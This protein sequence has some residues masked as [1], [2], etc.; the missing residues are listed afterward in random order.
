MTHTD[1]IER[2]LDGLESVEDFLNHFGINFDLQVVHAS[3]LHI[4]KRFR[5]YLAQETVPDQAVVCACLA[6][7]Y[8]DFVHSDALTERVFQVHKRAAGIATVAVGAIGGRR[9]A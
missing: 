6:R 5:D 1:A 3:R 9:S 8:G 4:L 2:M 7:A